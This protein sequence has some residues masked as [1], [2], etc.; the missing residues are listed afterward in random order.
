MALLGTPNLY[1]SALVV[2]PG[3]KYFDSVYAGANFNGTAG[4]V[5]V[6]KHSVDPCAVPISGG[7][8]NG[9]MMGYNVPAG[10][11]IA[12]ITAIQAGAVVLIEGSGGS[13]SRFDAV[14]G[15]FSE[16]GFSPAITP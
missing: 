3:G 7:F 10:F 4:E 6:W 8:G 2:V 13:A 1:T 5:V 16:P 15:Q 14:S 9:V 11:G 12:R